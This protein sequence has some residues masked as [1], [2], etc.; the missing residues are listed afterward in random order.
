MS[1]EQLGLPDP[2]ASTPDTT[3]ATTTTATTTTAQGGKKPRRTGSRSSGWGRI[4]RGNRVIWVMALVAVVALLAGLGLGRLIVSPGQAAADAEA[5]TA[6]L[7]T[8]PVESR[9]LANDVTIRG[10][11]TYADSVDVKLETGDIGG[12]AIVTGQVPE[13]G[14]T[15]SAAQIGL[16]VTGRPVIVMP[17]DLPVY[18][19]LRV[20]LSGPDVLQ[21]K[22]SLQSVGID[23]G[24][25]ASDTYDA[26]TAAA[27]SALYDRVG[28]PAPAAAEDAAAQVSA[29][30]DSVAAA[31]QSV[32]DAKAALATAAAGPS[33]ADRI[34]QDNLVRSA[35]RAV[36]A[37]Q[38]EENAARAG[39][40]PAPMMSVPDAEDALQLAY[41]RREAAMA[42]TDSSAAR[43]GVDAANTRLAEANAELAAAQQSTL[44]SLPASE[45]LFLPGLPRRVDEITVSRGST[46]S[47][48]VMRVSGATLVISGSAAESDA[49]LIKVGDVASLAM[50]DDSALNA[51][52][53][54]VQRA[55]AAG[56]G[57]GDAGTGETGGNSDG[58]TGAGA[59]GGN[60]G[61]YTVLLTPDAMSPEQLAAIQGTN[62]RVSLPVEST[63]GEVLAVPLAALTA[64]A[65][66]EARVEVSDGSG[67]DAETTLVEVTTGLAADG[68][69]EVSA[70]DGTLEAGDLVVVGR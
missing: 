30:N 12:P 44:T 8:V 42:P 47:G 67:A 68:Y 28:Y 38:A 39:T 24:D 29:A 22:Q 1:L 49:A 34:E 25:V 53:T 32:A 65:G 51:T 23:P 15:L 43:A 57:A 55:D 59:S 4:L 60:A 18:R 70:V 9:V 54:S 14:A 52:V 37:A 10:D 27:V 20:G 58:G 62:V 33:N 2:N 11:A 26:A 3:T 64:G 41:A 31:K 45:V 61:R 56:A 40:G 66:A 50:P 36:A 5:P 17:G 69:V 13:V 35:Q 6:G 16:E 48:A 63:A 21:L 19:T 7:I 46:I